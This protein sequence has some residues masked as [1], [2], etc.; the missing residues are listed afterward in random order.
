MTYESTRE[1]KCQ[2]NRAS[3]PI[4]QQRVTKDGV[5]GFVPIADLMVLTQVGRGECASV[6]GSRASP[7]CLVFTSFSG[8]ELQ[9]QR[10][11]DDRCCK[12]VLLSLEENCIT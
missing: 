6:T 3:Q 10:S 8:M 5:G 11:P 1:K 9:L 4:K 2:L 7:F 12:S